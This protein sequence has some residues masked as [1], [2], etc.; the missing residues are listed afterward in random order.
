MLD[1]SLALRIVTGEPLNAETP[2]P[3]LLE[4]ETPAGLVFV[5]SHFALPRADR[6]R[7]LEV[8]GAVGS[9]LSIPVHEIRSLPART[10]HVTLECAGNGRTSM[11]PVP[12]GTPWGHGA[13]SAVRVTGTPLHHVLDR[14]RVSAT[15]VEALF[16]GADRGEVAPGRIEPFARSLPIEAA[17]DPE[18]L[19]VWEMGG[20]PLSHDHGHPLRLVVPGWYGVASVKWLQEVQILER[21]FE[22]FFQRDHYVFSGDKGTPEGEP[23]RRIRTRSLIL[24]PVDGATV[25]RGAIEVRGAA[26]TGLG[27]IERV[28]VR[29]GGADWSV[30]DLER[31]PSRYGMCRWRF[32][33]NADA[34]GRHA[35]ACRATDSSGRTQPETRWNRL[36]YGNDAPHTITVEVA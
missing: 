33:W 29:A 31:A 14:T 12:A 15:A 21:P 24:D 19:L 2:L 10:V 16:V 26:W 36:G 22:G 3:A 5:R 6:D 1:P 11:R 9:P 34:P 17:L 30:V 18:T 27:E 8:R 28:E 13:L 20:E 35:L 32:V 4:T 7:R 23:V 25:R